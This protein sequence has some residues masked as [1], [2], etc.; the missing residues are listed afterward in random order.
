MIS[1]TDPFVLLDIYLIQLVIKR[2]TIFQ[3]NFL[4]MMIGL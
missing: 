4:T 3:L 1:N 2:V